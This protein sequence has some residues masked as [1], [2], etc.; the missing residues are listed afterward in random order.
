MS[1]D[2]TAQSGKDPSELWRAK[3]LELRKTRPDESIWGPSNRWLAGEL[4]K[5]ADHIEADKGWPKV[6]GCVIPEGGPTETDG[7]MFE[8]RVILSYP[9]PG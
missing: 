2:R 7:L 8:Y 4:R 5:L 3:T 1:D 6:Y 9:W